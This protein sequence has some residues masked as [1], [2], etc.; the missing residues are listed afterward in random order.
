MSDDGPEDGDADTLRAHHHHHQNQHYQHYQHPSDPP[1]LPPNPPAVQ[2]PAASHPTDDV[3]FPFRLADLRLLAADPRPAADLDHHHHLDFDLEDAAAAAH[4]DDHPETDPETDADPAADADADAQ[5]DRPSPD[6]TEAG[7]PLD[8]VA[9]NDAAS[10]PSIDDVS[11]AGGQAPSLWSLETSDYENGFQERHGRTYHPLEEYILPNDTTEQFRLDIQHLLWLATWD[12]R[13]CMCPKKDGASRVLDVGTGTGV[14][15]MAY[16]DEHPEAV[17]TGV[18]ISPIQPQVVAP[19]CF[20]EIYNAESEWPWRIPHDFVFM[21]HMNTAFASWRDTIEKVFRNLAPGGYIELQDN[22]FPIMSYEGTMPANSAIARWSSMLMEST[23]LLG[24]PCDAPSQ[25]KRLLEDAGFEGVV[26]IKRVWP[27]GEWAAGRRHF[28]TGSLCH[29]TSIAG[30][31]PSTLRLFTSVFGWSVE[32]TKDFCREVEAE[33]RSQRY[34]AYFNVY[35]VY[36]K[37]PYWA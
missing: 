29:D 31:E 18:D 17:V 26:E 2:L 24:R 22:T 9:A 13:L 20:F 28:V 15:A 7:L 11:I 19:N 25:F 37:K 6:A 36:G 5:S 30:L 21:R 34:H 10:L 14:W 4:R 1:I 35:C 3:L 16:A 33:I 8:R 32:E 27:I 12:G 23:R